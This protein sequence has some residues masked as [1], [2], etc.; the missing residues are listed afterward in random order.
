MIEQIGIYNYK[1]IREAI[2]PLHKINVLIG[3]N[4][5]GKSNFISFFE[6][7]KALY[8]QRL[9]SYMLSNGGVDAQLYRGRK[10]SEYIK[11]IIDYNNENAFFFELRPTIDD[12]AY[13]E[14]S[15]Y[16]HNILNYSQKDY[17]QWN[18]HM[19]DKIVYES[20]ISE[21][22]YAK[23]IQTLLESFVVYHFH[24]TSKTSPMRHPCHVDDNVM[25]RPDA[26][27]LAAIL[28]K[29]KQTDEVSYRFIEGIIRT[30][31]PYF[32]RF[33]LEPMKTDSS[34]IK[35]VWE[36]QDS[37]MYLDAYALS[38]G[39][40]RFIALT[41][42]LLQSDLP[43]TIIIDEPE[44]GLHPYAI[45]KLASMIKKA[46]FKSQIIIATQSVNLIDNF[47]IDDLI[48]V[49]RRDNQSVFN[50]PN[51]KDFSVWL[52]NYSVGELWEKNVLSSRP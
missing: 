20:K 16:Y 43:G 9:G 49:G 50:R 31:A 35:L 3:E 36:E 17:A 32:K 18:R 8:D 34:R 39:T 47:A 45:A 4:G 27:N 22:S 14:E 30:T 12:K 28:Y 25:L 44:L 29:L 26:S 37:Y 41:T 38:D 21:S 23:P 33:I 11:G 15:G 51:E 42:L 5:A 19:W 1:S 7:V 2:I 24:D 48:L 40:L 46:S 10:G 6:M 13:I 52:E